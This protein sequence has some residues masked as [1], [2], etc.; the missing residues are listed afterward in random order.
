MSISVR[1]RHPAGVSTLKL[2]HDSTVADLMVQVAET[3]G[4]P[5]RDQAFRLG[6]PPKVVSVTDTQCTLA[7][8]GLRGGDSLVVERLGEASE[9]A[10][11]G[12][13]T[14]GMSQTHAQQPGPSIGGLVQQLRAG[15]LSDGRCLHH[16]STQCL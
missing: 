12:S 13:G 1:L 3:A 8:W 5:P 14:A 2:A 10:Q 11:A 6:F 9:S 16:H 15:S 7:D 4:I